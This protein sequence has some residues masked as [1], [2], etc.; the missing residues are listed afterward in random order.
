MGLPFIKEAVS[1]LFSKPSTEKYPLV[2]K[3][4]NDGFRG[5][6]VFHPEL[7]IN[8]GMCIRVC[9]PQAITRT[10]EKTEE[11]DRITMEF[12]MGSCTFCSMCADFCSKN[13][14]ELSKEYSMVVTN[15]DDLKVRGSFIKKLPAAKKELSPDQL[16]KLKAAKAAKDG[17]AEKVEEVEYDSCPDA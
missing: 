7:C 5:K 9:A 11:G 14:I 4:V 16:A 1:Q 3:E 2:K 13:S 6:L 8:C 10:I 12:H 15:E 17:K